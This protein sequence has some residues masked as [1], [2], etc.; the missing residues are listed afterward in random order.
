MYRRGNLPTKEDY[1]TKRKSHKIAITD[2][3][4]TSYFKQITNLIIGLVMF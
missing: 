2:S 3:N 1:L 4:I